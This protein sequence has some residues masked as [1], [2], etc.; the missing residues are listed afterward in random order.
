[1]K[2]GGNYQTKELTI[3]QNG[4][5]TLNPDTGYDAMSSVHIGVTVAGGETTLDVG[6]NNVDVVGDTLVF[7]GG[8]E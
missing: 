3:N 4:N 8:N 2:L 5:Y 6:D 7:E 1:M